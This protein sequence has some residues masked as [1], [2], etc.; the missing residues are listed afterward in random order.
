MALCCMAAMGLTS[1]LYEEDE[2]NHEITPQ[3]IG[4]YL[5]AMKG[6]YSGKILFQVNNPNDPQDDLDTLD[7]AWSVT[8]DTMVIVNEF[9]QAVFLDRINDPQLKEAMEEA[10]PAPLRAKLAF[11]KANP[12]SF[13]VYPASVIYDIEYEGATHQASLV[14]WIN[15]SYSY[16]LYDITNKTFQMQLMGA[17]LYLDENTNRSYLVN[18][19]Y[20]NYSFPIVFTNVNLSH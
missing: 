2:D 11:Y 6:N 17:G 14:F 19:E 12:V 15:T 10:A 1:C 16:G 5:N 20:D 4:Q 18:N 9:P 7:I 3:E 13:L 8:T